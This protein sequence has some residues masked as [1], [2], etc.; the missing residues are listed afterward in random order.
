M[1]EK[2]NG[3]STR[4]YDTTNRQEGARA[5]RQAIL[6]AARERFIA[7]G[8]ARTPVS[9]IAR[10]AG[11]HVDTIYQTIGRKP[12]LVRLLLE[13]AISGQDE[14]VPALQRD[15]V[16]AIRAEPTARG[17]LTVYAAAACRIMERLQPIHQVVREAAASEPALAELWS[18]IAERRAS[19]MRLFV[20][21]LIDVA[22]LR[23]GLSID[24]A[25]DVIWS[26]NGPE[27]YT[28]LVVERGW[29]PDRFAAWL[30]ETW[31]R[32]LLADNEADR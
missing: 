11:V 32:L 28:L 3:S 2:S 10:Q 27:F 16:R 17:R 1:V 5:N 18:E 23:P 8:Y 25:A 19:N 22:P 26:T 29:L 24:E 31:A 13:T 21:E 7:D 9:V 6:A 12:D 15:Y 30:A 4:R 20:A 14:A